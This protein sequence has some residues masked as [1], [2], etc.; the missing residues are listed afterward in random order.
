MT[1]R[2]LWFWI[3]TSSRVPSAS[4]Q[5]RTY[6]IFLTL[7]QVPPTSIAAWH[8]ARVSHGPTEGINNLIKR[9]KRAAFG[10]TRFR[11]FRIRVLL[12]AGKPNWALLP[13][14]TPR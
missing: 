6:P 11:N 9:V 13:A 10:M 7:S 2:P 3:F 1:T 4:F 8:T 12:Y 14:V 5:S